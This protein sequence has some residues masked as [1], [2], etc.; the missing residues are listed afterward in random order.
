MSNGATAGSLLF[1]AATAG[2]KTRH[3]PIWYLGV[4]QPGAPE[5]NFRLAENV[6]F[7]FTSV[8]V[9]THSV[10]AEYHVESV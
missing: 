2:A 1:E 6:N 4:N 3:G 7:G 8:T 9:T 10:S 5:V